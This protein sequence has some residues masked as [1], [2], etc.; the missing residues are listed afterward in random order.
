MKMGKVVSFIML[1]LLLSCNS[2]EDEWAVNEI[3]GIEIPACG[4]S[5]SV[6]VDGGGDWSLDCVVETATGNSVVGD[7]YAFDD[8]YY[9]KVD[10]V[11]KVPLALYGLGKLTAGNDKWGLEIE[12]R[13]ADKFTF[14][15][16]RNFRDYANMLKVVLS[17]KGRSKTVLLTQ[18]S[19]GGFTLKDI[20]YSNGCDS[21]FWDDT[22]PQTVEYDKVT[23]MVLFLE[24]N[25]Y[26]DIS[27]FKLIVVFLV[28]GCASLLAT[29]LFYTI[30]PSSVDFAGAVIIGIVEELGKLVIV[31]IALLKMPRC[32]HILGGLLVGSAVG[33]GFAAFESAGYAFNWLL[34]SQG[35]VDVMIDLILLRGFLAPGGH[36]T[37]AAITGAALMIAKGNGP[38]TFVAV[39]STRFLKLFAIP[40]VLHSVWDMPIPF[41]AEIYLMPILLTIAVWVVVMILINMGLDQVKQNKA[42]A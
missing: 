32:S 41:G 4:G 35:D 9:N 11:G 15:F 40:V 12:R 27:L 23:T 21:V 42:I 14:T 24:V 5:E 39:V 18:Q 19:G 31:Y 6:S 26:R 36:V 37:W 2:W 17:D 22:L 25:A 28:G 1:L 16:L 8:A 38:L 3:V 33:A 30:F 34:W 7:V 20:S 13:T 10:G 29:M